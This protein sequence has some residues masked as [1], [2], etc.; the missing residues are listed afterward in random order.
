MTTNKG[1]FGD[2]YII[3]IC[4]CNNPETASKLIKNSKEFVKKIDLH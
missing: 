3:K 1:I 4:L 2:V